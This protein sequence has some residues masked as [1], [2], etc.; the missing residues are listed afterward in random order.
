MH[1]SNDRPCAGGGRRAAGAANNFVFGS[2]GTMTFD[3]G[4][5]HALVHE[6]SALR[7]I[8]FIVFHELYR[9]DDSAVAAERVGLFP[10]RHLFSPSCK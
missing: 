4:A 6:A 5:P 7:R 10:A 9:G 8:N 1:Q 2:V 3:G